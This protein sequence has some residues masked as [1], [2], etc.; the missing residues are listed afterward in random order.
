MKRSLFVLLTLLPV[1][2][3]AQGKDLGARGEPIPLTDNGELQHLDAAL[4]K[5]G[6]IFNEDVYQEYFDH[7][8]QLVAP[9]LKFNEQTWDWLLEHPAVLNATFALEY[10]PNGNVIH[11]F[12]KLAKLVGPVYAEKYQ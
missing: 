3:L 5:S 11:N 9:N 7:C 12:V 2:A 4:Y 8:L 1:F 10:P 6:F